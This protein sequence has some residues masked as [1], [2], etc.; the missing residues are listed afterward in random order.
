MITRIVKLTFAENKVQNFLAVF[1]E[2]A[3]HIRSFKGC[4]S[5]T[6]LRDK[7]NTNLFFTYS[8]WQS[9]NDLEQYRKSE[10][11]GKVWGTVKL[12][13]SAKAEAWTCDEGI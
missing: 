3:H 5:M 13:F 10:L 8:I 11:F 9:E 7:Q 6:L 2:N 1:N 4:Q 12:Y